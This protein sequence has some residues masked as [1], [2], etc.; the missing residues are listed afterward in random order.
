ML[1]MSATPGFRLLMTVDAVG[2]VWTY[3]LELA[4]G[5]AREGV[6]TVLVGLGPRPDEAQERAARRI[7]RLDLRWLDLPLDWLAEDEARFAASVRVLSRLAADAGADLDEAQ[8]VELTNI[9]A[10]ENYRARFNWAFGI[11]DQGF[12]EG[13]YCVPPAA[14]EEAATSSA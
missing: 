12:S 5:L 1:P 9:I 8:L 6:E 10:L 14:R 7:E 4:A 13:A 2:G 11:A 3:A